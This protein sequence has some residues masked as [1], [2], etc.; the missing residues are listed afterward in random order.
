MS[1]R[2]VLTRAVVYRVIFKPRNVSLVLVQALAEAGPRG[3][4]CPGSQVPL[5]TSTKDHGAPTTIAC[6]CR[7]APELTACDK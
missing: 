6:T 4:P 3:G 2:Y 5:S 1:L 7:N